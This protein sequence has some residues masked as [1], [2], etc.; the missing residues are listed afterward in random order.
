LFLITPLVTPLEKHSRAECKGYK[1]FFPAICEAHYSGGYLYFFATS[2]GKGP[3]D[4]IGGS[5]KHLTVDASL[6]KLKDNEILTPLN[7]C[8]QAKQYLKKKNQSSVHSIQ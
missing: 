8:S 6:Q 4:G 1:I 7:L 5:I 3:R 2:H